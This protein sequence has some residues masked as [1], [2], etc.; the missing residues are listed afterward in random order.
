M[1]EQTRPSRFTLIDR[2]GHLRILD[3]PFESPPARTG[4]GRRFVDGPELHDF[5]LPFGVERR[6][7]KGPQGPLADAVLVVEASIATLQRSCGTGKGLVEDVV[8]TASHQS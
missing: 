3:G 2:R 1:S 8:G 5:F 7:H 6:Q 4:H